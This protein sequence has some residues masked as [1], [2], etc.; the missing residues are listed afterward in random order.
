MNTKDS[1]EFTDFVEKRGC[2]YWIH[3]CGVDPSNPTGDE[4]ID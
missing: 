4:R 2:R 1:Y 3:C